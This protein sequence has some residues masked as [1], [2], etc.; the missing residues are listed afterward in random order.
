MNAAALLPV[1]TD[2]LLALGAHLRDTNSALSLADATALAVRAWIAGDARAADASDED[3]ANESQAQASRS[4]PAQAPCL[5]PQWK[6]LFLPDGT[7]VRMRGADEV[8]HARV[9]GDALVFRGRR[10]SP[11][12][13]TI[14][15]AGNGRNAW[16]DLSLRLPGE[17]RF[18]RACLLRRRVQEKVKGGTER[19][20]ESPAATIAA[21]AESMSGALRTALQLVEHSNAQSVCKYERR[22]GGAFRRSADVLADCARWIRRGR[23]TRT[24]KQLNRPHRAAGSRRWFAP[25]VRAAGSRRC[26]ICA[27]TLPT[28]L[29]C[30]FPS[31]AFPP[32]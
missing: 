30:A 32:P 11:R 25:L 17:N 4:S 1:D 9:C 22:I 28:I 21:A 23:R 31:P 16:R 24:N 14:A 20:P 7:D 8:H 27:P 15:V 3:G 13:F 5:R 26:I 19:L 18:Q 10:L 29:P 2:T 12:Q 6:E